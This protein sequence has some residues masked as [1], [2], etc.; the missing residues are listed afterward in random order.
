MWTT[1]MSE[2]VHIFEIRITL[3]CILDS[4]LNG[5]GPFRRKQ[6]LHL[7][8]LQT[9]LIYGLFECAGSKAALKLCSPKF[10]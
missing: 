3:R 7:Q 8:Q 6:S 2:S 4:A 1:Q 9:A 5:F 10:D